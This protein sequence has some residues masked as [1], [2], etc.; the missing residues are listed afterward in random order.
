[1]EGDMAA[2]TDVNNDNKSEIL[3]TSS[4]PNVSITRSSN[5]RSNPDSPDTL[6]ATQKQTLRQIRRWNSVGDLRDL[7]TNKTPVSRKNITD[8]VLEALTSSDVLNK[9][10]PILSEK[11]G[12]TISTLIESEI[13]ACVET[14]INPL[15]EIV[16]KQEKTIENHEQKICEQFIQ[17]NTLERTVKDQSLAI[18]EHGA[19]LES[20]LITHA[21]LVRTLNFL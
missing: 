3:N 5:K 12:E 15:K 6:P 13:Q 16:H 10:I 7:G 9:I 2:P 20:Q 1:M 18:D 17:I 21:R 11:I 14:H 19:E 8:K 4:Q